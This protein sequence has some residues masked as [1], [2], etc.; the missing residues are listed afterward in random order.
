[1]RAIEE[2]ESASE[3]IP[4]IWKSTVE[5]GVV[6]ADGGIV[7]EMMDGERV[8]ITNAKERVLT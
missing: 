7:W 6:M 2:C 4:E 1:M 3:F 8:R 5:R